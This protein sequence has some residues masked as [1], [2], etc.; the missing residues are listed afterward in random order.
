[1]NVGQIQK[2]AGG[3]LGGAGKIDGILKAAK[4]LLCIPSLLSQFNAVGIKN[5]LKSVGEFAAG[6]VAS[7]ASSILSAV[8]EQISSMVNSALGAAGA[9]LGVLNK[10]GGLVKSLTSAASRIGDMIMS[11]KDKLK[12]LKI[13]APNLRDFLMNQQN[14]NIKAADFM[15]CLLKS[16]SNKLTKKVVSKL[17]NPLKKLDAQLTKLHKEIAADAFKVGGLM[18]QYVGRNIRAAEK[19]TKQLDIM[20][21]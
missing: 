14:C 4:G 15:N 6:L 17:N 2:V 12:N 16:I 20:L 18:E 7:V 8:T 10:L 9:V 13:K 5:L 1:M 19:I 3:F 21:R 11:A